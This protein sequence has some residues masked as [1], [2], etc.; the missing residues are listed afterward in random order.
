[1]HAAPLPP[2]ARLDAALSGLAVTFRGMTA[3]PDE[4]NCTCHWG[5]DEDLALLKTP[6]VE[7]YPDLLARTWR[8]TDWTDRGAVLR[9]VLPQLSRALV[10]GRVEAWSGMHEVGRWFTMAGWTRWPA[11]HAAPVWEFLDAWWVH[12][13]TGSRPAVPAH[14]LLALVA[15]A[16]GTLTPWLATWEG[17]D[18]PRAT[19]HLAEAAGE[20]EYELLG[21][22][23]PWNGWH[24]AEA[25]CAELT[26]WLVRHAA[27]RLRAHGAPEELLHRIRLLGVTGDA[28]WGDPH[29]PGHRY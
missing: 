4:S 28:R 11:D 12:T 19:E 29:W 9:R 17:L 16:S 14:E 7:L 15:E 21:D 10:E 23:L 22:Q 24:D 13:L 3:R 25:M 2:S 27:P 18:S 26:A 8:A 6:D 20:W 1:M 5:S